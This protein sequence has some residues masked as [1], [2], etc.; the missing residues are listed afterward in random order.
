MDST[1]KKP[2][3]GKIDHVKKSGNPAHQAPK[4][5]RKNDVGYIDGKVQ[6]TFGGHALN[7]HNR[8]MDLVRSNARRNAANRKM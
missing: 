8:H 7:V 6:G 3:D 5:M 1:P 2:E 4:K